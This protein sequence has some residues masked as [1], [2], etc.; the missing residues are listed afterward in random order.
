MK[1]RVL[2]QP[3]VTERHF[4][5]A[6]SAVLLRAERGLDARKELQ[7]NKNVCC[8]KTNS[9]TLIIWNVGRWADGQTMIS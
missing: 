5:S 9:V 1:K 2:K 8:R 6:T 7:K 4:R 3:A